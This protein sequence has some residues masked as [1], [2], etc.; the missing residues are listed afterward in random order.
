[1]FLFLVFWSKISLRGKRCDNRNRLS[2][3]PVAVRIIEESSAQIHGRATIQRRWFAK[4]RI[5]GRKL[6]SNIKARTSKWESTSAIGV[7]GQGSSCLRGLCLLKIPWEMLQKL[8]FFYMKSENP[9]ILLISK[10]FSFFILCCTSL[11]FYT[12][13]S[14]FKSQTS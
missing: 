6:Q 9:R 10:R 2:K 4:N 13:S 1:M 7:I 14:C 5:S 11:E 3:I 12:A 8:A